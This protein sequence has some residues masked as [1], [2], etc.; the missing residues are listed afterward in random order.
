ME[1][2]ED[3]DEGQNKNLLKPRRK[4]TAEFSAD[5]SKSPKKSKSPRKRKDKKKTSIIEKVDEEQNE[6]ENIEDCFDLD[7]IVDEEQQ[8]AKVEP[9][10]QLPKAESKKT[11]GNPM[12]LG[13]F[14]K[15]KEDSSN[16]V[17]PDINKMNNSH[18]TKTTAPD[19]MVT[20]NTNENVENEN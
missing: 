2:L 1:L 15:K 5:S 13:G 16:K 20:D 14:G 3:D 19:T 7:E 17:E 12:L 11:A 9:V 8:E 4:S 6:D 18:Y 10:A